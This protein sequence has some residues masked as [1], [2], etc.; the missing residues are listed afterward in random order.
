MKWRALE[1]VLV[2]A[3][4]Y[5]LTFLFP[6]PIGSVHYFSPASLE[7]KYRPDAWL[8]GSVPNYL[9]RLQDKSSPLTDHLVKNG[10]WTPSGA[11]KPRWIVTAHFSEQWKDGQSS[12][13]YPLYW[14]NE[15]WIAWTDAN[16]ELARLVWPLFLESL[17]REE[18]PSGAIELLWLAERAMSVDELRQLV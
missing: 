6:G 7:S 12:L 3:I 2:L 13:H 8:F 5:A 9:C 11:A 10:Y 16:P 17:R 15:K 18:S 14:R 4:L 1:C